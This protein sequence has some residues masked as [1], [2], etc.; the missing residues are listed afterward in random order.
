MFQKLLESAP[1]EGLLIATQFGLALADSERD[2]T[3]EAQSV[4][5]LLKEGLDGTP[6]KTEVLALDTYQTV[7]HILGPAL[8]GAVRER[9]DKVCGVVLDG[10]DFYPLDFMRELQE[11]FMA[12][13][14]D[15]F[16]IEMVDIL[17]ATALAVGD[18]T[19]LSYLIDREVLNILMRSAAFLDQQE[20][21][22]EL[23]ERLSGYNAEMVKEAVMLSGDLFFFGSGLRGKKK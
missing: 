23:S 11:K 4:N 8:E 13:R 21:V 3:E 20:L 7:F 19:V 1:Q 12:L 18:D 14:D 2:C 15:F 22:R 6:L 5:V 17:H 10:I 16:N 9:F